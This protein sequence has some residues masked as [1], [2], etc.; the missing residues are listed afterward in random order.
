MADIFKDPQYRA[1]NM[2]VPTP[3]DDLGTVTLAGVVPKLSATPGRLRWAG[4]R[5]GQDT[6][7]FLKET[8]KLSDAEIDRLVAADIVYCDPKSEALRPARA[9]R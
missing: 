3:D 6:R 5:T 8:A 9:P 7:A 2:L 1:R 4:H